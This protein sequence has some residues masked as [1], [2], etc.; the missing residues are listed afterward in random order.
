DS[1]SRTRAVVSDRSGGSRFPTAVATDSRFGS[2]AT[3]VAASWRRTPRDSSAI[4]AGRPIRY[5]A[6]ES[7]TTQATAAHPTEDIRTLR[8]PSFLR[9]TTCGFHHSRADSSISVVSQSW[10]TRES[11]VREGRTGAFW[12]TTGRERRRLGGWCTAT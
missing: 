10:D 8:P 7:A 12:T 11:A 5:Q 1:A 3:R 9:A 2:V 6:N 4:W